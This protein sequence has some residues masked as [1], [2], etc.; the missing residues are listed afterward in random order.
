MKHESSPGR[1]RFV[2]TLSGLAATLTAPPRAR[3]ADRVDRPKAPVTGRR[4]LW[5][6]D[7]DDLRFMAFGIRRLW[8][9][10]DPNDLP[11]PEKYE[12]LQQFLD[13]RMTA[14]RATPVDTLCYCGVFNWPAW[15]MPRER[16]AALGDDP[17]RAIVDF[18]HASGKEFFFNLR[19]N[20][21]HSSLRFNGPA[22]WEP[23]RLR[24]LHLLQSKLAKDELERRFLP[25]IRGESS[26]YPL[27]DVQDRRGG[28]NRDV[29]SWSAYDYAQPDV[30]EYFLGLIR[31]ICE[32]YDVDGVDLDWLRHPFFFRF[33]EERKG[34]P[35]MN[36]F[37]RRV[38]L[39]VRAAAKRRG[40]PIALSMRVPDT[41]DRAVEIGLDVATWIAEGWVD[42]LVAGNGLTTFS[43]PV[44]AWIDLAFPRGI[45]VYGCITRNA[46]GLNDPTALRGASQRLWE[47]G[48]SG[49]Y[50][51]NHFIPEEYGSIADG[52]DRAQLARLT[53]SYLIDVSYTRS[54]NGTVYSGPLPLDFTG[55]REECSFN[56]PLVIPE[57]LVGAR[58]LR[59]EATWRGKALAER[60]RWQINGKT[61]PIAGSS[62][63]TTLSYRADDLKSGGNTLRV[64][65]TPALNSSS[66]AVLLQAVKVIVERG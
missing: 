33:G 24:N 4:I 61:A 26:A 51:F 52:A 12:S 50:H 6:N 42:L 21:C 29:Q 66:A 23:F 19:M 65:V 46:P 53:K 3:G 47:S 14:L 2:A 40:R 34:I 48:V 32:R 63:G 49:L 57:S 37:V 60:T 45:P 10:R 17:I 35:L 54:Q 18:T 11:L 64:T 28:G 58:S 5:N 44:R 13:L 39:T 59:L 15:E 7:G 25:W 9:A 55:C 43:A 16:I 31:Q 22:W 20:D 30:R 41:P 38:A 1:R 56:L 62:E 8:T 27:Q 36:D